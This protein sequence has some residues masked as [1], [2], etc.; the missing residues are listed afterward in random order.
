MVR[1]L[2]VL[3]WFCVTVLHREVSSYPFPCRRDAKTVN[4]IATA[5]FSPVTKVCVW[6][7]FGK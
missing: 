3:S 2:S 1:S 4:V 6:M 7:V 5:C